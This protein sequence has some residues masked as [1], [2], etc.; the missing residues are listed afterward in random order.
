VFI[1]TEEYGLQLKR[2][3]S[4]TLKRRKHLKGLEPDR[5]YWIANAAKM[6]GRRRLDLRTDPPPDLAIEVDVTRSSLDRMGI[7]ATLGVPEVWRLD[8]GVLTFW[9][10]TTDV[11]HL[12]S[13]R[14]RAFPAIAPGDLLPFIMEASETEDEN[15]VTARFRQWVREHRATQK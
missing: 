7:Y 2:G 1:L 10:L 4:T 8:D 5:C 6:K 11:G 12:K 13:E 3:G 14:S 9:V 15:A